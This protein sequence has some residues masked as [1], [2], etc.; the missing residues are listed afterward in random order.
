MFNGH[1]LVGRTLAIAGLGNI[2]SMVAQ[3]ALSL[4]M[5]VIGYDPK[6]SVEAA[7]R[8]PSE[9]QKASSLSDAVSQADFVSINMPY[10][11][12]VTHHAISAEARRPRKRRPSPAPPPSLF[13]LRPGAQQDEAHH[14]HPELLAR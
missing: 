6:I 3:A 10:I 1:E 13:H 11:K 9:V 14:A 12:G 8:L 5:N 7:W 4:G 2:G